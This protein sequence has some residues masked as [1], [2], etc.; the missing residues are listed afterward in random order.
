[1][2]NAGNYLVRLGN[3]VKW[4]GE[5]AEELEVEVCVDFDCPVFKI[6]FMRVCRL[7]Q[8]CAFGFATFFPRFAASNLLIQCMSTTTHSL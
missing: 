4:L 3:F 6:C 7:L 2:Y 8:W 5:Q 1:M